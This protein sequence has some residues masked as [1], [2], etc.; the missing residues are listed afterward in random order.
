MVLKNTHPLRFTTLLNG[1][2]ESAVFAFQNLRNNPL[3]TLLSLLGVTIGIF[4]ISAILALVDSLNYNLKSSLSELGK[5]VIYVQKW[6]WTD[7]SNYPWWKYVNR[8]EVGI[9]EMQLLESRYDKAGA[10]AFDASI[11]RKTIKAGEQLANGISFQVVSAEYPKVRSMDIRKGRFFSRAEMEQSS[12]AVILGYG[13]AQNLFPRREA[14]GQ[15]I[16]ALGQKLQVVG[17]LEKEGESLVDIGG[18]VDNQAFIPVSLAQKFYQLS[19]ESARTSLMVKTAEG[20][21][22]NELENDLTGIMRSIRNL[23]PREDNNFALNRVSLLTKQIDQVL[24]VANI[25]GWLIAAFSILVGGFGVANIMF[26]SVKERTPIIGIQKA[27]G[28][29]NAFILIQVL[30][31]SIILCIIGG[32][33]GILSVSAIAA[34]INQAISF[35]L[36]LT[37]SNI[38]TGLTLSSLIGVLAGFMP[39]YQASR[40][41]PIGA[42]RYAM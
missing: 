27:I 28:A 30:V 17:V 39:A 22:L 32:L 37:S 36:T 1:I 6:P 35:Q 33:I 23:Q 40:M 42:I 5:D 29:P 38:L 41:D 10:I 16:K 8:P 12:S 24:Q 31:E 25:A 7:F 20:Q 21:T 4:C 15:E 14:L 19:G 26:V 34:G 18:S 13:V 11:G 2:R 3:R 9:E